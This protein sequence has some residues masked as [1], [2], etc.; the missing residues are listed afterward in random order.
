MKQN[1]ILW[2]DSV[3]KIK[4]YRRSL[5]NERKR[6]YLFAW[7]NYYPSGALGDFQF[8]F[9]DFDDFKEQLEQAIKD[10]EYY[11]DSDYIAV[12]D[13]DTGEYQNVETTTLFFFNKDEWESFVKDC[14]KNT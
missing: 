2:I 10:D 13:L 9:N 12:L 6:Y 3:R 5:M 4:N 1:L 14:L 7:K 11:L 8:E